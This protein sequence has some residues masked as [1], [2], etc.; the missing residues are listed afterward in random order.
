MTNGKRKRG[1]QPVADKRIQRGIR[2]N[3]EEWARV[4]ADAKSAGL[5]VSAYVRS[6]LGLA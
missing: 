1:G 6:C 5:T 4:K 3:T 2:L